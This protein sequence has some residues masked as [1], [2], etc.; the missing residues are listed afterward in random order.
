VDIVLVKSWT[1]VVGKLHAENLAHPGPFTH[2]A[3]HGGK[4][5]WARDDSLE[6]RWKR[7]QDTLK[8]GLDEG[9]DFPWFETVKVDGGTRGKWNDNVIVSPF[10]P[11]LE[12]REKI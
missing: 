5:P 10:H 2:N 3:E 8:G 12:V 4:T 11:V 6:R 7:C 1:I 9:E